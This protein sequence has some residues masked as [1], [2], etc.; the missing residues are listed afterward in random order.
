MKKNRIISLFTLI[1]LLL[2]C[3]SACS[4]D[5]NSADAPYEPKIVIQSPL[6]FETNPLRTDFEK[7]TG[8]GLGLSAA[9][10]KIPELENSTRKNPLNG[11][12]L[13]YSYSECTY[14]DRETKELGKH[15]S[16]YDF[17]NSKNE[18]IGVLRGTDLVCFYFN[19]EAE[20]ES[21]SWPRGT[22][23]E[24]LAASFLTTMIG[25]EIFSEFECTS[26]KRD[27]SGVY[28]YAVYFARATHGYQTDEKV[29]VFLDR[30]GKVV[31][32]NGYNLCKYD[33]LKKKFNAEKIERAINA[34][35][36]QLAT[37]ETKLKNMEVSEPI[38]TT[39]IN[40]DLYL[41]VLVT[42]DNEHGSAYPEKEKVFININ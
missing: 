21:K 17:Y 24:T 9:P 28:Y 14:I 5:D 40:G 26:A 16:A 10:E 4:P 6:S 3:F 12:E 11:Q 38:I 1:A 34:L 39:N 29:A 41:Q 15:Y 33:S 8:Y 23:A 20:D 36:S 35:T 37:Y 2:V 32:Y 27:T 42:F 19:R 22:D 31:A 7:A 18:E 13:E 30:S 25:S